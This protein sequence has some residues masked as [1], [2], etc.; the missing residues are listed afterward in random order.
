MLH[1]YVPQ[2][3][4]AGLQ[5][6]GSGQRLDQ[7]VAGAAGALQ[8][9]VQAG[10]PG[11]QGFG[12]GARQRRGDVQVPDL[13]TGLQGGG[14]VAA[15]ESGPRCQLA[16]VDLTGQRYHLH[17]ALQRP[18]LNLQGLHLVAAQQGLVDGQ[19][20]AGVDVPQGRQRQGVIAARRAVRG[21][22][23][24][25]GA[26]QG[27]NG[28]VEAV[29]VHIGIDCRAFQGGVHQAAFPPDVAARHAEL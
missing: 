8:L 12:A 22:A 23:G 27:E 20:G 17:H 6:D 18:Q 10:L 19:V 11:G 26:G 3:H 29:E 2:H 21:G 15:I 25:L 28:R 7:F 5:G 13:A 4:L 24:R 1:A 16:A 9:P 14:I